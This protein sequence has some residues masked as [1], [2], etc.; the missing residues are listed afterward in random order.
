FY[1]NTY[2][3]GV[4]AVPRYLFQTSN[5]GMAGVPANLQNVTGFSSVP[6]VTATN[7]DQQT[8][9]QFQGDATYYG[10]WAGKHAIKGGIQ[11]DRIGNNVDSGEQG[12]R[13]LLFWGRP[14]AGQ[15]GTFGY[16]RVRSNGAIPT[17]GFITQGDVHSN[18]IGLFIQD[19]W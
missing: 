5:V 19:A 17:R 11:L 14:F 6:T 2:D 8:R 7:T 3:A 12:N 10:A 16:Y 4:P 1:S 18:N 9:L 13:V 15:R